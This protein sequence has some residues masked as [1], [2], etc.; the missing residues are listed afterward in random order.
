MNK[1]LIF[2]VMLVCLLAF[3]AVWSFAQNSPNVRWEY[4]IISTHEILVVDNSGNVRV[5]PEMNRLGRE[6]WEYIGDGFF[7]RRLP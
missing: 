3:V 4:H 5:G 6:G 1:K 2:L 7:K